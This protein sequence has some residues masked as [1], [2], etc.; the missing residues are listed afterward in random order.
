MCQ[1]NNTCRVLCSTSQNSMNFPF[2]VNCKDG[3]NC[4]VFV[5][6]VS[7]FRFPIEKWCWSILHTH[8]PPHYKTQKMCHSFFSPVFQLTWFLTIFAC[9]KCQ[10]HQI[11]R[12]IYLRLYEIL[13]SPHLVTSDLINVWLTSHHCIYFSLFCY[14]FDSVKVTAIKIRQICLSYLF[15]P[16]WASFVGLV[17]FHFCIYFLYSVHFGC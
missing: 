1:K 11:S 15:F 5:R 2:L 14:L 17:L 6:L 9:H 4:V 13:A 7:I 16:L 3:L 10:A 12:L 8:H